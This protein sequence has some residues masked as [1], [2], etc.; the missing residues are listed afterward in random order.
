[1]PRLIVLIVIGFIANWFWRNL[2]RQRT[3]AGRM[4]Q[5]TQASGR[6]NGARTSGSAG[7]AAS[8]ERATASRRPRGGQPALAEPMVRCAFCQTHLPVSEAT[9]SLGEHFC[10]PRHA[11][12]YAVRVAQA[13]D[14]R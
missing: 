14:G 13:G 6:A 9:S 10:H 12:D 3:A 7:D 1:M 11:R 2:Q 5:D 4:R 8:Q